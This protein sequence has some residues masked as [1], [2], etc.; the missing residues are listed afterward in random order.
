MKINSKVIGLLLSILLLG[1]CVT[2]HNL[3]DR[4]DAKRVSNYLV[5]QAFHKYYKDNKRSYSSAS[6]ISYS[7]DYFSKK[8]NK[9]TYAAVN[10]LRREII[11]YF[12]KNSIITGFS[13]KQYYNYNHKGKRNPFKARDTKLWLG[14]GYLTATIMIHYSMY[15]DKHTLRLIVKN[16]RQFQQNDLDGVAS[17]E[18]YIRVLEEKEKFL[19]NLKKDQSERVSIARRQS[20]KAKE[21]SR[22]T[23]NAILG[24]L[25]QG[26]KNW[27]NDLR[28]QRSVNHDLM[29]P[30]APKS[31]DDMTDYERSTYSSERAVREKINDKKYNKYRERV[32]K[33]SSST[34]TYYS[35]GGTDKVNTSYNGKI[36]AKVT[37]DVCFNKYTSKGKCSPRHYYISSYE[38]AKHSTNYNTCLNGTDCDSYSKLISA[39]KEYLNKSR[40]VTIRNF[41]VQRF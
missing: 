23:K 20:V 8:K 28:K 32:V 39:T 13:D 41:S 33:K 31:W 30:G 12:K 36:V 9:L 14:E 10:N 24:G 4:K 3:E 34:F 25:N 21:A 29:V 16:N 15:S 11:Y 2:T 22:R 37:W 7:N 40:D 35:R 19:G 17:K 26:V 5:A 1:G 18:Q 27:D 6:G 38:A